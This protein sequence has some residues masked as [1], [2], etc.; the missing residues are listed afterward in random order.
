MQCDFPP[1][2]YYK[3]FTGQAVVDVCSYSPRDYTAMI[4]RRQLQR[5][6]HN[7]GGGRV[8]KEG[9]FNIVSIFV[10][11]SYHLHFN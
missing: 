1:S 5:D 6:R 10:R 2:I 9:K 7:H 11:K 8:V 4:S 3:I